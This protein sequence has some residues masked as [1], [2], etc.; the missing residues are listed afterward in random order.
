LYAERGSQVIGGVSI[1]GDPTDYTL[2]GGV[3]CAGVQYY[4]LY[5]SVGDLGP[6]GLDALPGAVGGVIGTVVLYAADSSLVLQ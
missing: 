2:V 5:N 4:F 1:F 6:G 3:G